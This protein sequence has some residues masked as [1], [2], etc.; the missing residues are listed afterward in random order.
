MTEQA[1]EVSRLRLGG[2]VRT[3]QPARLDRPLRLASGPADV[4]GIGMW[5]ERKVILPVRAN[6]IRKGYRP[7]EQVGERR[8]PGQRRSR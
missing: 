5:L 7:R 2:P 3:V 6:L 8:S 1:L 4:V